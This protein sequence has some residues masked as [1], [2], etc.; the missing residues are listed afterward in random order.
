M[1]SPDDDTLARW[2]P[3][4][5]SPVVHA[6]VLTAYGYW[7]GVVVGGVLRLG[8]F[9]KPL[10]GDPSFTPITSEPP[11]Y[12]IIDGLLLAPIIESIMLIIFLEIVTALKLKAYLAAALGS[13]LMCILHY[14][15][16][17]TIVWTFI[18]FPSF[19][20]Q[21]AAYFN[22]RARSRKTAAGIMWGMHVLHNI[23]PSL[24]ALRAFFG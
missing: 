14:S 16:S 9:Q 2:L 15:H 7:A 19:L 24:A 5:Q 13:A 23:V 17:P 20:L 6:I 12:R 18:H 1:Q 8:S 11:L 21:G 22:W 10:D 3:R 4:S